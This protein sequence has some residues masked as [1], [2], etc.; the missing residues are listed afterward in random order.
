MTKKQIK[1]VIPMVVLILSIV[2]GF[3]LLAMVYH[4]NNALESVMI[5]VVIVVLVILVKLTQKMTKSL[6][7]LEKDEAEKNGN[8]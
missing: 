8:K 1:F 6:N 2:V 7:D 5:I 4:G 3:T